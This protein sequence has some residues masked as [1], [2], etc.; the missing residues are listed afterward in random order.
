MFFVSAIVSQTT[1]RIEVNGTILA[2]DSDVE[3]VTIYNKSSNKGTITDEKGAFVLEVAI[4]DVIEISALQF[5]SLSVT[6]DDAVIKNKIL[7]IYLREHVNNLDAV[8]LSWG[9][10]GNIAEDIKNVKKPPIIAINLGNMNDY[11]VPNDRLGEVQNEVLRKGQL[12][13]GVDF[14]KIFGMLGINKLLKKQMRSKKRVLVKEKVKTLSD[15]YSHEFIRETFNIPLDKI[16]MFFA[17]LDSK[18][19]KKELLHD[20]NE[21]QRIEFLV[22]QSNL[23]LKQQDVK[24]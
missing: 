20:E 18:G 11:E 6:I 2:D 14:I 5:E 8:L 1:N 7:R 19:V 13:N 16:E 21:F 9:L 23:F 4:N 3:A 15:L 24:N 22:Q 10:S 17:F 12:Y